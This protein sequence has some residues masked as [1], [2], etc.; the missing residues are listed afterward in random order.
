MSENGEESL[1]ET[2]EESYETEVRRKVI[3]T[4]M[5]IQEV[6]GFM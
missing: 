2:V 1:V 3:K 4:K 6:S 5:K